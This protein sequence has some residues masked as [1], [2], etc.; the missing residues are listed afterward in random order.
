MGFRAAL[1]QI[2]HQGLF[3][4]VKHCSLIGLYTLFYVEEGIESFFTKRNSK[5]VLLHQIIYP[6]LYKDNI[7]LDIQPRVSDYIIKYYLLKLIN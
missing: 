7:K 2:F 4:R 1:E 5:Y 6:F 3:W